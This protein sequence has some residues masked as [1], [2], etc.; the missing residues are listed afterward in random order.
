[1]DIRIGSVVFDCSQGEL[2]RLV[3]FWRAALGYELGVWSDDWRRLDDPRGRANLSFQVVPDP[4][5][6]KNKL[7]LDLYT[8]DQRGEVERLRRLGATIHRLPEPGDDF[9]VLKD[10]AGNVFCVVDKG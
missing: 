4:T 8:T 9:V 7:H 1:V 10:P 6:G 5:P 3:A 2:D